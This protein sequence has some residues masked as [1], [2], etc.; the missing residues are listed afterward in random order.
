MSTLND[1]MFRF[2]NLFK[3]AFSPSLRI[4]S[5]EPRIFPTSGFKIDPISHPLEED[6]WRWYTPELFYP[7]RISDVLQ[8]KYQILYKLG[9][10]ATSTVWMC[11]DLKEAKSQLISF[12]PTPTRLH[13]P[14]RNEY[15]CMKSM[16]SDYPSV[17]CEIRAYDALSAASNASN[18]TGKMYVRHALDHFKWVSNYSRLSTIFVRARRSST[19]VSILRLYTVRGAHS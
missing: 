6:N 9:Y 13:V 12:P 15:V 17:K 4:S 19:G 5:G 3:N 10:G 11:R 1:Q 14:S 8:S 18:S 16:V 7:V 2:S